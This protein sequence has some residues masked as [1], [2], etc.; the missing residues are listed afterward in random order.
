M[1]FTGR[2][3]SAENGVNTPVVRPGTFHLPMLIWTREISM[4]TKIVRLNEH[5]KM[6][7][8]EV[9][10]VKYSTSNQGKKAAKDEAG[11]TTR[12]SEMHMKVNTRSSRR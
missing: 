12:N 4:M 9:L 8:L 10:E 1:V 5:S 7:V 3:G 11:K 2:C 6:K